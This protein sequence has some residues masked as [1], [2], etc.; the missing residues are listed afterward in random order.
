MTHINEEFERL[1]PELIQMAAGFSSA[2][3]HEAAGKLGALPSAIKPV[4][5]NMK[6]C[7]P[8]VT[9]SSLPGNNIMLHKAIYAANPGDVLV[10]D[11][12]DAYEHGY[13]GDIMTF[14]AM[15]R[16]LKGLVINGC[17]RD[18]EELARLNFPVF[19]RGLSIKGT[20]K[21]NGGFIN[22][23]VQLGDVRI[24]PGDLIVGDGDGVVAIPRL[25][26][27]HI[28]EK[29]RQREADEERIRRE[30]AQGRTTLEIYGLNNV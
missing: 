23:P 10:V 14:A 6:I 5:S 19:S 20:S 26:A 7:G 17:V 30:L 28:L 4:S 1:S 16:Q 27:A 11:V 15:Q 9:V 8:A 12:G 25:D 21:H 3:L 13:W 24:N 29:A 2:T 18:G 22:Q